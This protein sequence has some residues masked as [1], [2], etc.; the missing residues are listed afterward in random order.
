ML[1]FAF[2]ALQDVGDWVTYSD[3]SLAQLGVY[4][5]KGIGFDLVYAVGCFGFAMLFGPA[6]IRTLKRFRTRIQVTWLPPAAG[7]TAAVV[8]AAVIVGRGGGF[9]RGTSGFGVDACLAD[10]V[11]DQGPKPRW[12]LRKRARPAIRPAGHGLG[13]ARAL[14]R[15][16]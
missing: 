13:D 8:L 10:H 1:G 6:L 2:T 16:R 11:P 12:G 7:V 4:V 14:A 3:H 15:V 9:E 5:G